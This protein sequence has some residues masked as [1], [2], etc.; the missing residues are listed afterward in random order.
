VLDELV[1]VPAPGS[2]LVFYNFVGNPAY[3][4]FPVAGLDA[5]SSIVVAG[6]NGGTALPNQGQGLYEPDKGL[7]FLDPGPYTIQAAGGAD[8]GAFQVAV[9]VPPPFAWTNASGSSTIN[10]SHGAALTW[11]GGDPSG[12]VIVSGWGQDVGGATSFSCTARAS[13]ESFTIHAFVLQGLPAFGTVTGALQIEGVSRPVSFAADG[14]D[15][16]F[17]V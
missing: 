17:R 10:R 11:S 7:Q 12:Y 9:T 16:G 4:A 6:A 1:D 3:L 14:L 8:V 13:D 15:L 2:C 5:G